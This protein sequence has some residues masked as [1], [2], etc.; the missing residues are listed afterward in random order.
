MGT[1]HI[2]K[3][4]L[5]AD[6]TIDTIFWNGKARNFSWDGFIARLSGAFADLEENGEPRTQEERVHTLL[7]SVRD[8]KKLAAAKAVVMATPTYPTD[9]QEAVN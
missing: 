7:R 9:Y 8:P 1:G 3:V 5:S 2:S 6:R 4:M